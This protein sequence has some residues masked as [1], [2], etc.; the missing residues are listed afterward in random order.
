MQFNKEF[1]THPLESRKRKKIADTIVQAIYISKFL[2]KECLS[3]VQNGLEN[4]SQ[5]V[6]NDMLEDVRLHLARIYESKPLN[7]D[8]LI[9][10][11]E[12]N[13]NSQKARDGDHT[14]LQAVSEKAADEP[15]FEHIKQEC[16]SSPKPCEE[17]DDDKRHPSCCGFC[18]EFVAKKSTNENTEVAKKSANENTEEA[19]KKEKRKV[20]GNIPARRYWCP[21]RCGNFPMNEMRWLSMKANQTLTLLCCLCMDN[22]IDVPLTERLYKRG[23]GVLSKSICEY[24][25]VQAAAYI[26]KEMEYMYG[27]FPRDGLQNVPKDVIEKFAYRV[28]L[29]RDQIDVGGA[30][31][32]SRK[33]C[34]I[35]C[36]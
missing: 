22:V 23:R 6:L 25:Y 14:S 4:I 5:F 19:T 33:C 29:Y 20:K 32:P 16:S 31:P 8:D 30:F 18:E 9:D 3:S 13:L 15:M 7:Y 10:F 12:Y 1:V 35:S 24:H 27:E 21:L 17:K 34:S 28:R 11:L 36:F 2:K 26:G